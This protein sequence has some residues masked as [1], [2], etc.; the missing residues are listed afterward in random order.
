MLKLIC[1]FLVTFLTCLFAWGQKDCVLKKDEDSIKVFTCAAE[2]TRFK[3]IRATFTVNAE[4]SRLAAFVLDI[5]NYVNWQ[6]NTIQ[7]RTIKKINEQEIIFYTE[8]AAPWPVSNRDMVT[9]LRITQDPSTK[10]VTITTKSVAGLVPPKGNTVRVP[11]L[12]ATW[13]VV[14]VSSSRL[15]VDYVI[16]IDP[17]GSV[18]A[19]MINLVAAQAPYNSF[20][21]LKEKIHSPPPKNIGVP[22]IID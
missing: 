18:P 3:T 7:S 2:Q 4:L 5:E 17:G 14:P 9:R 12:Q 15:E 19:W 1:A 20:I 11:M 10:I 22:F 16:Q 21:N 13:T 8:I 6:Y